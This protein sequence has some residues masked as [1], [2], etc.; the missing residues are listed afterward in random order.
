[1][2]NAVETK[3]MRLY[4]MKTMA[5]LFYRKKPLS[6]GYSTRR[7]IPEMQKREKVY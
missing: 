2:L 4:T 7:A 3:N 5:N 6:S 1:M